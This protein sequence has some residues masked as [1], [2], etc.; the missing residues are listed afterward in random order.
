[1]MGVVG[2]IVRG[3]TISDPE[4]RGYTIWAMRGHRGRRS[5]LRLY[6]IGI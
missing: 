3:G 5:Q 6:G 4:V 2:T 1:M